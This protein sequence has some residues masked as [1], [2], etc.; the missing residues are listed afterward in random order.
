MDKNCTVTDE[1]VSPFAC[2]FA[3]YDKKTNPFT[4]NF[5]T[6]LETTVDIPSGTKSVSV[7]FHLFFNRIF[8][9]E[10]NMVN[11]IMVFDFKFFTIQSNKFVVMSDNFYMSHESDI[12]I[13]EWTSVCIVFG[14]EMNLYLDGIKANSTGGYDQIQVRIYKHSILSLL[15]VFMSIGWQKIHYFWSVQT[16]IFFVRLPIKLQNNISLHLFR[17]HYGRSSNTPMNLINDF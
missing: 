7:C 16:I 12:K 4:E 8:N 14:K 6:W 13:K 1:N 11:T 15:T 5:E 9:A 10:T 17:C 3:L 2:T